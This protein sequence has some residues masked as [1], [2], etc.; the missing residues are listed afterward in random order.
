MNKPL[1]LLEIIEFD[2]MSLNKALLSGDFENQGTESYARILRSYLQNDIHN[3]KNILSPQDLSP[4]FRHLASLRLMIL[5]KK[6]DIDSLKEVI[7]YNIDNKI[8]SAERDFI[9]GTAFLRIK[10]N[11][12]AREHFKKAYKELDSIGAKNKGLKALMNV[13]VA[14]SRI[15]NKRKLIGDYE[16]IAEK[17]NQI[18]NKIIQAICIHNISKEFQKVGGFE[19]ALKYANNS[20]ELMKGDIGAL[21]YYEAILHRSH[22]LID[23]GRYQQAY[24]D[25]ERAKISNHSQIKNALK[26]IEIMLGEKKLIPGAYLEP[27]WHSKLA[28]LKGS[29]QANKMT[30]IEEQR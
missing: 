9:L 28:S 1:Q 7:T 10:E 13:V 29:L 8:L 15:D 12:H 27:A 23:L 22:V 2:L 26:C 21:H 3:L 6:Q 4:E 30:K 11:L 24:L 25:F 16:L 5:E 17:A 14:E 19:L 20:I 18:G